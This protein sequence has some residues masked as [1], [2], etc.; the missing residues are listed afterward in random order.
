M[1]I[2]LPLG[3]KL[4]AKQTDEGVNHGDGSVVDK[5]CVNRRTVPM[6]DKTRKA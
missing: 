6:I 4:S 1:N 2:R 5:K 3:G